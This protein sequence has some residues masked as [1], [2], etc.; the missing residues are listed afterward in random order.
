MPDETP[1]IVGSLAIQATQGTPRAEP[2][3][4]SKVTI[5]LYHRNQLYDT[6]EAQLDEFGVTV[7]DDLPLGMSTQPVV[8]V[9][10]DDMTYQR[11]GTV[12]D[13]ANPY[14][15]IEVTC[16]D[17]T[18]EQP[19]WTISMRHVMVDRSEEGLVVKEVIVIENPG[20]RTWLGTKTDDDK[21]VTTSFMMPVSAR[22][23]KLGKG[24]HDWCCTEFD[25]G[26][27]VNHLPLM[28]NTTEINFSYVVPIENGEAEI[29]VAAP[30][31]VEHLMIVVPHEM[32]ADETIGLELGGAEQIGER[33]VRYYTTSN[34]QDGVIA[35][36]TLTGLG[37]DKKL[38]NDGLAMGP[39]RIVAAIGGGLLLLVTIVVVF[40]K[41]P[42][43]IANRS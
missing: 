16:Y 40:V 28:P 42:K 15:K 26:K 14:Q 13:A 8:Q 36:I 29:T 20:E 24:F 25:N 17:A 11:I 31:I 39:V 38:A 19:L 32:A 30:V 2:I 37:S 21:R 6:I 7:I 23:L 1:T 9:L 35:S 5:K 43:T 3:R 4:N 33:L 22:N 12:M 34:Q 18:D 10:H 41:S 27:L